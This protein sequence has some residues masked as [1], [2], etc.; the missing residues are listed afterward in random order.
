MGD[1][2]AIKKNDRVLIAARV[3]DVYSDTGRLRVT[4]LNAS[5][6]PM[7]KPMYLAAGV[8]VLPPRDARVLGALAVQ[9]MHTEITK[10]HEV[11]DGISN[12]Q[13]MRL[14]IEIHGKLTKLATKAEA[15]RDGPGA[16]PEWA[17]RL[18]ARLGEL[19]DRVII[20]IFQFTPEQANSETH[21]MPRHDANLTTETTAMPNPFD[22]TNLIIRDGY[23]GQDVTAVKLELRTLG[24]TLQVEGSA[25]RQHPDEPHEEIGQLLAIGR[26]LRQL[27]VQLEAEGRAMSETACVQH[28]HRHTGVVRDAE[29]AL[30]ANVADD[31][32]PRTRH[33]RHV[34]FLNSQLER[35]EADR[36]E[37]MVTRD[38]LE[39]QVASL[40]NRL[41]K[42]TAEKPK[43]ATRR[44]AKK[45]P[46]KPP[47]RSAN[48]RSTT[49][50]KAAT[51]PAS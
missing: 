45:A 18:M 1:T 40:T 42:L 39:E 6:V 51:K 12:D 5:G 20:E 13:R 26:G 27:G 7:G 36:D 37:L 15:Y 48:G 9:E 23:S 25:K 21:S 43:P 34:E 16:D 35:V 38:K 47:S 2:K 19:T 17:S 49:A 3:N 46:A 41:D 22:A 24:R 44:T 50:K 29:G 10:L 14:G 11:L 4:P 31:S 8:A 32:I 33:D 30:Q 28:D